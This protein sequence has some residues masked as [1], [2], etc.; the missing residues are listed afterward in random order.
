MPSQSY[1][2]LYRWYVA[3]GLIVIGA[4]LALIVGLLVQRVWRREAEADARR[5]REHLA[6]LTRVSAMGELA[7]SLA[8][9]LNQPLTG[10][11][12][13]AQAAQ[14]LLTT[15]PRAR[16]ELKLIL[17]DIVDDDKRAAE[18]ISRMREMVSKQ[19]PERTDVDVNKVIHTVTKLVASDSII[20]QVSMDL[21]LAPDPL[22]VDADR[23]QLEQVFLNLL[24]NALEATSVSSR[25]PHSVVISTDASDR[26]SVHVIVRDNGS[27]VPAGAEW[28]VFEPFYTTKGSGMGMGLS[29]ARSIIESH[30]GN[31]WAAT[32]LER[33]AEF[34]FTL[35]RTASA[36]STRI[37]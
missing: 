29:I 9:E 26:H 24:L 6:H 27:G 7:A 3:G 22:I 8:H 34:H 12:A 16:P 36:A 18:V 31:I 19:T 4:Q 35:P 17:Q 20:R 2:E 28:E 32:A 14:R 21:Q 5:A 37:A 10:I 13:N 25:V 15:D 33:G 23:V 11:L 30:G 1:L